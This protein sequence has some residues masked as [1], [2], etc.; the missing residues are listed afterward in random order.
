MGIFDRKGLEQYLKVPED[1]E[2][3]ALIA[4]GH[5]AETPNAPKRKDV[6]ALL[7]YC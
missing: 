2:I 1:Q 3:M 4:L 5:P 6:E 7:R